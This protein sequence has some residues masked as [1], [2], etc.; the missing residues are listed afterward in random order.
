LPHLGDETAMAVGILM[1]RYSLRRGEAWSRLQAQARAE[2]R[3]VTAQARALL[4][5]MET[6]T[7]ARS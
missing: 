1:H 3:D 2:G 7:L 6:L 5:A 4:A